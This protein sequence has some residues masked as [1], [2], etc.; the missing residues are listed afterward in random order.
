MGL[1]DRLDRRENG[2]LVGTRPNPDAAVR[3]A[4]GRGRGGEILGVGGPWQARSAPRGWGRSLI[5]SAEALSPKTWTRQYNGEAR[6]VENAP[7]TPLANSTMSE[8]TSRGT[9]GDLRTTS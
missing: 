3:D 4:P 9:G 1:R 2:R 5:D 7:L 6:M 8:A